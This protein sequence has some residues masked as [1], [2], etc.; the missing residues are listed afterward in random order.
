MRKLLR[1]LSG[2]LTAV[3]AALLVCE[4]YVLLAR[5]VTGNPQPTVFGFSTAVVLSGSMEP[6]IHVDDLIITRARGAYEVGD[7]ITYRSGSSLTTHRV[8]EVLP[9]GY[10]T[11]GDAN[12]TPDMDI[13]PPEAV[14]GK[15]VGTV[16]GFGAVVRALRSPLGMLC[17]LTVGV[18]LIALPAMGRRNGG[19]KHEE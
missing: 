12:N 2:V 16:R 14:V 7:I 18:L 9:G 19:E 6:A 10:R 13:V 8:V 4:C 5:K 15:V 17:L 1:V 3:I 11:R